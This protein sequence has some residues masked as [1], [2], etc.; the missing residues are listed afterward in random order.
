MGDQPRQADRVDP[1]ALD[2]AAAHARDGSRR[3]S[4]GAAPRAAAIRRAVAI[5]VP[6]GASGLPSWCSSMISAAG[7]YRAA[8]AAK[9]CISTAPIA[10]FG[11]TNDRRR[12]R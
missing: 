6:D 4:A 3:R 1:D 8:T 10:K 2:V 5:A 11:A 7:R 9:R 12:P